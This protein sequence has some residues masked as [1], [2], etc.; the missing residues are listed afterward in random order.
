M[1]FCLQLFYFNLTNQT[2]VIF[3]W[4]QTCKKSVIKTMF[5]NGLF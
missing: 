5:D 2:G 4:T 1:I 3:Y